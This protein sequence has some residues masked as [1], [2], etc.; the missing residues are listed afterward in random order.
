[1]NFKNL[2]QQEK[3]LILAGVFCVLLVGGIV[4]LG[5]NFMNINQDGVQC[6]SS[7]LVYA[8]T[9]MLEDKGELYDCSCSI[10][11]PNGLNYPPFS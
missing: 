3:A 4:F 1:M 8:E 5:V 10:Y 6:L 9:R 7:P 11:E 2:S